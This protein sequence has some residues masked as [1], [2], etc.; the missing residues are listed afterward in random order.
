[1]LRHS[2]VALALALLGC[3]DTKELIN[4]EEVEPNDDP[5]HATQ[6]EHSGRNGFY[7]D[8]EGSGEDYFVFDGRPGWGACVAFASTATTS[9]PPWRVTTET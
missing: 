8:C 2:V 9:R 4:T 5:A 6:A 7:G 3:D 1:M